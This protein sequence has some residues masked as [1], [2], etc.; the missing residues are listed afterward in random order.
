VLGYLHS[1]FPAVLPNF[2]ACSILHSSLG[3]EAV[4]LKYLFIASLFLCVYIAS[5]KEEESSTV[6]M[7]A[8]AAFVT[9]GSVG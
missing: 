4:L 1:A 3:S 5:L 2:R 6:F 7:G 9:S 8:R